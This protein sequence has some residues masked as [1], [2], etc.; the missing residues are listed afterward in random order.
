MNN[1]VR[2]DFHLIKKGIYS[3]LSELLDEVFTVVLYTVTGC[4]LDPQVVVSKRM[5]FA[6]S[7]FWTV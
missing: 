6:V 7:V 5:H 3:S 4:L 1:S 2:V